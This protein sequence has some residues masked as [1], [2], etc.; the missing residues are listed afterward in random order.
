MRT[1]ARED[2]FTMVEILVV[3]IIIGILAAIAIPIY[4]NQQ[5]AA[6]ESNLTQDVRNAAMAWETFYASNDSRNN[7]Y[8][9]GTSGWGVVVRESPDAVFVGDPT[10]S[11][12]PAD[13]YPEGMGKITVS[14]GVALGIADGK[15]AS[16]GREAGEFCVLGNA[17]NTRFEITDPNAPFVEM[18]K[19]TLYYDSSAGGI[20]EVDELTEDG[21]CSY[22]LDRINSGE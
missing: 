22:Y 2:G 11:K 13:I 9:P 16:T 19:H 14:D 10:R 6:R 21:A 18:L 20:K 7:N 3:I 15:S 17:T 5:R 4:L 1:E 8:L 12:I